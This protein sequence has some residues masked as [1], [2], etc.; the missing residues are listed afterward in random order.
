MAGVSHAASAGSL[1]AQRLG[2]STLEETGEHGAAGNDLEFKLCQFGAACRLFHE[3]PEV[4]EPCANE[5][6]GQVKSTRPRFIRDEF[7]EFCFAGRLSKPQKGFGIPRIA[8]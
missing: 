8:A 5:I 4:G 3:G 7:D 6:R 2:R 1:A